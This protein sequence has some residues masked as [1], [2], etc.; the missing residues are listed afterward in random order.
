MHFTTRRFWQCYESLPE[1]IKQ[2]ADGNYQ[3]LKTDPSH[4][5]LH[6]K[7]I[8]NYWSVRAGLGH[9]ALGIEVEHGILWFWIG[10]HAE[11]E[12]LIKNQ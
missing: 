2:V 7:K 9:R 6:F 10:T 4:P 8:G 1:P 12:R 3:L 5:S 11:Y